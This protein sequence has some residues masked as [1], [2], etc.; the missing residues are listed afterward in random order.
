MSGSDSNDG[1]QSSPWRSVT[2]ALGN[3]SYGDTI[4]IN[5]GTYS[6]GRL[7]VPTGVS[8]TSTARDNTK[9]H[10]QPNTSLSAYRP[11]LTLSSPAPGSDGDQIISYL[12][13]DGVNGSNI[14]R[15]GILVENRNNVRIHHCNIHDFNGAVDAMGVNIKSTQI[16]GTYRWW[17][18]FP[19]DLQ[20]PGNDSNLNAVWPT[21]PVENFELD[22]NTITRC[23]HRPSKDWIIPAVHPFNLKNSSIHHNAIDTTDMDTECI[24]A[25]CAFLWNVDVFNNTLKMDLLAD[26]SSY[27]IE[28]WNLRNGCEFYNN[29]ANAGFS[30]TMGKETFVHDNKIVFDTY[31][32]KGIGIEFI[33]QS[34]GAVYN[35]FIGNG[36]LYGVDVGNGNG[37]GRG[38][39]TRNT[40]VRNNVFYK[41]YGSAIGVFSPG[42]ASSTNSNIVEGINIYNNTIDDI[43]NSVYAAILIQQE[44][45]GEGPAILR[46]ISV[47]NNLILNC[48][49]YCGSTTGDTQ[50]ITIE[51]N[52]FWQNATNDWL[53]GADRNTIIRNPQLAGPAG[54]YTGY[55]IAENALT[56]SAAVDAGVDVGLQFVGAGPDIGAFEAGSYALAAPTLNIVV[57]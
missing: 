5:D 3:A 51:N 53:G 40:V 48:A 23:G 47:K 57:K 1:S 17:D 32:R 45:G 29:V 38:Y 27:I 42:Q 4:S 21:N 36:P 41:I 49:S 31:H 43:Q 50:N 7:T 44:D 16:D 18:Y 8:L 2:H 30:I 37:G 35:N 9:V 46:N 15:A 22:N 19:S 11:F 33:S 10:L 13:I 26:R 56:T 25:A 34:E 54:Q 39:I 24:F 12:E 52:I 6:E 55:T 20:A 28:V 14:A